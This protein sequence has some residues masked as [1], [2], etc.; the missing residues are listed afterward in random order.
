MS[1]ISDIFQVK[2]IILYKLVKI[3]LL[4]K[5]NLYLN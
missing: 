5:I 3:V 4:I 2:M 1:C